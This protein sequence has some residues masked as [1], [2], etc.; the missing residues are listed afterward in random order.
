MAEVSTH[1]AAQMPPG[2]KV[3]DRLAQEAR[4][5]PDQYQRALTHARR[6]GIHCEDAIIDLGYMSEGD[7]LKYLANVYRT[8]FVSTAK[9]A[10]ASVD[11]DT[12]RLVPKKVCRRLTCF[13]ILLDKRTQVLSVVASDLETHD[14][15]KQVQIVSGVR[16]VRVYVARPAAVDALVRKYWEGDAAAFASIRTRGSNAPPSPGMHQTPG[17]PGPR[18]SPADFTDHYDDP[19]IGSGL[20]DLNA[21]PAGGF[22][23]MTPLP[24]APAPQRSAPRR[25]VSLTIEAPDIAA[26]LARG[27]A[28]PA[29]SAGQEDYLETL[30]V[31]VALLERDRGDLRGH[32]AQVARLSRKLCE[33]IGLS[34]SQQH[35]ILVAAYLHDIGKT[36]S[37]HLTA[38][39]VAQYEGHRLVAQKSYLTPVRMFESANLPPTATEAITHLYERFDGQGFPDRQSAKEVPLASRIVAIVETY[40]DLTSHAK[41]P[42]RK[43]LDAREGCGALAKHK[44]TIFDPNLVDLFQTVVLG[45][46]LKAKL[47]SD[48]PTVLVVDPDPEETTVL[49]LRLIEHGFDVVIARN[50]SDALTRIG[51]GGVDAI[52]SEVDLKPMDGFALLDEARK[53]SDAP[54]L[55][56]T[57]R[58]DRETVARGFER[59]AADFLVKPASADVVAAKA[60]QILSAQRPKSRGV[61]G[62][63]SE[64]SLPDVVQVLSNGRKSGRLRIQS[65]GRTGEIDFSEGAIWDARY[66]NQQGEEAF[67]GMLLLSEG[68]FAL[69]PDGRPGERRIN[70]PTES[71][72][73]E[74]M[75]RLDEG[76]R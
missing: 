2:T 68:E 17:S 26:E 37:Y 65:G 63:L 48:R 45:D 18:T 74:G 1:S 10:R 66:G 76:N 3:L 15:E 28:E 41:N 53:R 67:Y 73:L 25:P 49:E 44:G 19:S 40:L 64:M 6:V 70:A 8:R 60:Q 13:P 23:D 62:Q 12:L 47:L 50:A 20:F 31:L 51:Q 27:V 21:T 75:R 71:L 4:L 35:G 32:S 16:E 69:D 61:S 46:D 56:L 33:R 42:F 54:V 57:R 30:N 58:S 29:Q 24:A 52:V 59:G 14:V 43:K 72:L 36:G 38:L 39:N 22:G 7:L 9:L 34:K 5:S 55:F 11:K